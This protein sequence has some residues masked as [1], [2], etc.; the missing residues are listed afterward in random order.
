[1]SNTPASHKPYLD[2]QTQLGSTSITNLSAVDSAFSDNLGLRYFNLPNQSEL[3]SSNYSTKLTTDL[4][5]TTRF[6]KYKDLTSP[7]QQFLTP[8]KNPRKIATLSHTG[9]PTHPLIPITDFTLPTNLSY[10]LHTSLSTYQNSSLTWAGSN[11]FT[12]KL[13]NNLTPG[14]LNPTIL[15]N[16]NT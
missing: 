16:K 2:L 12:K 4:F 1:L 9:N 6:Y 7:N 14:S 5:S 10:P 15:S 13:S 8:D 11:L 3:L